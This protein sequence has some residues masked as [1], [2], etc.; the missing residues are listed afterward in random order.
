MM[1]RWHRERMRERLDDMI[2]PIEEPEEQVEPDSPRR[3]YWWNLP[4]MMR[5]ELERRIL[6]AAGRDLERLDGSKAWLLDIR[7]GLEV[8]QAESLRRVLREEGLA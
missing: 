7:Y 8:G 6:V 1:P 5:E 2:P 4:E 3:R